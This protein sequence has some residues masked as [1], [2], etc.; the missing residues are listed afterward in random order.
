MH[1]F[2]LLP[3]PFACLCCRCMSGPPTR[4][5]Q[6]V[7]PEMLRGHWLAGTPCS[8]LLSDSGKAGC[9][10]APGSWV[11]AADVR[12]VLQSLMLPT[13]NSLSGKQ[14]RTLCRK[15]R[16]SKEAP[17]RLE[18]RLYVILVQPYMKY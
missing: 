10:R 14:W 15:R 7:K 5:S 3:T 13:A 2:D 6:T 18:N 8:C 11:F 17:H 16:K 9:S 12:A 1:V 4:L